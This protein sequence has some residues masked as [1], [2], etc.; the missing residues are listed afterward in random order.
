MGRLL[1]DLDGEWG[2]LGTAAEPVEQL[3][4]GGTAVGNPARSLATPYEDATAGVGRDVARVDA[5]ALEAGHAVQQGQR[6]V[7]PG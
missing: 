1:L 4:E 7:K 3:A 6:A 2:A 5:D